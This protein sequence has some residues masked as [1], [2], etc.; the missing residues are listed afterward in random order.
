MSSSRA[1]F[2]RESFLASMSH[3]FGKGFKKTLASDSFVSVRDAQC[4]S[5]YPF[6]YGVA[7]SPGNPRRD[8]QRKVG[9]ETYAGSGSE[10]SCHFLKP[11]DCNRG[12]FRRQGLSEQLANSPHP[13]PMGEGTVI[14]DPLP[15]AKGEKIADLLRRYRH[16][17]AADG[18]EMAGAERLLLFG[19]ADQQGKIAEAIDAAGDAA[20]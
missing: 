18:L 1:L 6:H 8:F 12:G 13:L 7:I 15:K 2:T 4:R 17:L 9:Q 3:R 14:S 11:P 10:S 20:A 19:I 5:S 16:Q